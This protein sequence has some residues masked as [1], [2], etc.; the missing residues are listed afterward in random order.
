MSYILGRGEFKEF[1]ITL[2][3]RNFEFHLL[4]AQLGGR[5]GA[6]L[7][8]QYMGGCHMDSSLLMSGLYGLCTSG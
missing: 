8:Y 3:G 6:R 1:G 2:L 5:G 4:S 7:E